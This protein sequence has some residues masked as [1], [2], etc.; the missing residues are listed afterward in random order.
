MLKI[1]EF[2]EKEGFKRKRMIF[3]HLSLNIIAKKKDIDVSLRLNI[4]ILER[5]A[6]NKMRETSI[7]LSYK[8]R[9]GDKL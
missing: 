1:D 3:F 7:L 2:Q 6:A 9:I 4:F 5:T 8:P